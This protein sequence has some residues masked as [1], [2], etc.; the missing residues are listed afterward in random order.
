MTSQPVQH[1][2]IGGVDWIK[3]IITPIAPMR[4][5]FVH[6]GLSRAGSSWLQE[7]VFPS[8]PDIIFRR[9]GDWEHIHENAQY[10]SMLGKRP[11][12]L[13]NERL[14][15]YAW[16]LNSMRARIKLLHRLMPYAEIILVTRD[17]DE[18]L[19][20]MFRYNVTNRSDWS[21]KAFDKETDK[22]RWW[23]E[24]GLL[25]KEWNEYFTVHV[26]KFSDLK[27]DPISFAN[28]IWDIMGVSPVYTDPAKVNASKAGWR[29]GM[30]RA[31]NWG[32]V[33]L[34]GNT[35]L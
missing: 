19:E 15:S 12:V 35:R 16:G 10:I 7:A 28:D 30:A 4:R 3:K 31:L 6:V 27:A 17:P 26:L 11:V 14:A 13:S 29:F 23:L 21:R 24:P 20:S 22:I 5:T 25:A 1:R 33:K 18:M 8:H 2:D 9:I 32:K 34:V